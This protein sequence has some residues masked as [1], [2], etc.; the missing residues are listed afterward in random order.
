MLLAVLT[1]LMV[2]A[3]QVYWLSDIYVTLQ[4]KYQRDINEAVRSAD[5]EE[6]IIRVD[7][8]KQSN[9]G[10]TMAVSV[11]AD[12]SHEVVEVRNEYQNREENESADEGSKV[13]YD[14]LSDALKDEQA[15][16]RVGLYMQKGIHD[17]LDAILPVNPECFDSI[18]SVKLD[19]LKVRRRYSTLYIQRNEEVFDTICVSG[20]SHIAEADT[21]RLTLNSLEDKQ[22]VLLMEK[23]FVLVP[24]QMN[25]A[26]LFSIFTLVV[27]I[28]AFW[29]IIN[30]IRRMRMLDEMKADFTN[31]ITHELKTPIAV[32][33]AANDALL[34]FSDNVG[35]EKL[36]KYLGI[37]QE[38]LNQLS[39]LVEQILSLSMD[40]RTNMIIHKEEILLLPIIEKIVDNQRLKTEKSVVVDIDV[41][42]TL[43]LFTDR[44]H[45]GNVLNNL[46]DNAVKYSGDELHLKIGAVRMADGSVTVWVSDNG[47]GISSDQ[48]RFVF[49]KFYRAPHG[50]IHKVKGYGL[51]LYYVKTIME[52]LGGKVSIESEE[53]VG[54]TFKLVFK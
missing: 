3:Y 23:R 40:K 31:N 38:Q 28:V 24:P 49:D 45:L 25:S 53:G 4:D 30:M 5:F 27:L 7:Q 16:M 11:G 10:G 48:L 2:T 15:L 21:F 46:I 19:S 6:M 17:G 1:V 34:N 13:P 33:Y 35:P 44:F 41:P 18:L 8:L 36:K 29:Y 22:Y 43:S 14:D 54:S 20:V 51:G 12:N 50:N 42:D 52:R 47:I 32:A 37:C 9:Y 39:Q 26:L